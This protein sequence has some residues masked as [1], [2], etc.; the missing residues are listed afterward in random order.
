MTTLLGTNKSTNSLT[1]KS[2]FNS[3]SLCFKDGEGW[4]LGLDFILYIFQKINYF[5]RLAK[6]VKQGLW[7]FR[8]RKGQESEAAAG[9]WVLIH[10]F[11]T[12]PT[13]SERGGRAC[14]MNKDSIVFHL[15]GFK[16]DLVTLLLRSAHLEQ[17]RMI[18]SVLA[19]WLFIRKPPVSC[20]KSAF[21][22]NVEDVSAL[23][24]DKGKFKLCP[25]PP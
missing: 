19:Q 16:N 5:N 17:T 14:Q 21:F 4:N 6:S 15:F 18:M 1:L 7:G 2:I 12:F 11:Q 23:P 8:G 22:P 25:H 13:S 10:S 9:P 24:K 3:F 20:E